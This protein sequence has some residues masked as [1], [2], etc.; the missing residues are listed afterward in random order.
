MSGL[1]Q[2]IELGKSMGYDGEEL[3]NFV[4]EQQEKEREERRLEREERLEQ[5]R[6]AAEKEREERQA[7]KER[8]ERQAEKE[9][10][11]RHEFEMRKLELKQPGWVSQ[12]LM[13]VVAH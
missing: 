7:E 8:E 10:E 6:L 9:R 1:K 5:A 11:Q 3:Q 2:L 12:M 13:A 4:K